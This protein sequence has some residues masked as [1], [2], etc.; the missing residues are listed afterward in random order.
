MHKSKSA[1]AF[2][3]DDTESN[4]KLVSELDKKLELWQQKMDQLE[5]KV[6]L[7]FCYNS[8]N[9]EAYLLNTNIL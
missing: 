8:I 5:A 2:D 6:I 1:A 9:Y 4:R 7:Y 3:K